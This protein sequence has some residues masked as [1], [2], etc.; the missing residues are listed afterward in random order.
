MAWHNYKSGFTQNIIYQ[1]L[2]QYD[3]SYAIIYIYTYDGLK[4]HNLLRPNKI[5]Y[6]Y[7]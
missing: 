5:L 1:H 2:K 4:N 6:S 3:N 7:I